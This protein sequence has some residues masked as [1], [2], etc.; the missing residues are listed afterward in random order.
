MTLCLVFNFDEV[1]QLSQF[2]MLDS[3]FTNAHFSSLTNVYL[4]VRMFITENLILNMFMFYSWMNVLSI[5]ILMANW[6]VA[7]SLPSH[8]SLRGA[9]TSQDVAAECLEAPKTVG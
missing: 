7:S 4:V 8:P 1:M 6:A 9:A 2:F 5:F 3:T